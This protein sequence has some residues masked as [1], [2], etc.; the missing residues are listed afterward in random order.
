[1]HSSGKPATPA[2][3]KYGK[4]YFLERK[5]KFKPGFLAKSLR[6]RSTLVRKH[7]NK[8]KDTFFSLL[9]LNTLLKG[10]LESK[11]KFSPAAVEKLAA[12]ANELR[13]ISAGLFA[14]SEKHLTN[15]YMNFSAS[16]GY[17]ES[18]RKVK[19]RLAYLEALEKEVAKQQQG[20]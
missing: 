16:T 5:G 8:L 19:T 9:K 18:L 17:K 6:E 13:R 1:M 7:T 2:M 10:A 4:T 20:Q 15:E 11:R 12:R 14:E 3:E